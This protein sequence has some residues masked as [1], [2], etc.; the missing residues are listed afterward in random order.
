MAGQPSLFDPKS[1]SAAQDHRSFNNVLQ[2]A[3]ISRPW[4]RLAP[5]Q[6]TVVDLANLLPGFLR[7]AFY[8]ILHQHRNVLLPFAQR[9]HLNREYVKPVKQVGSKC[10]RGNGRRYITVGCGYDANVG[11]NNSV[12]S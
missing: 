12:T 2:L 4:I 9:R 11:G 1:V 7:V 8:E 5:L 10:S 6:R 3:D